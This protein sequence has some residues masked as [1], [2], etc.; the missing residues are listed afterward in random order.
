MRKLLTRRPIVCLNFTNCRIGDEQVRA[1]CS[2]PKLEQLWL[3]GC[4][5]SDAVLPSVAKIPKLKRLNLD[6]TRVN[7]S[8]LHAFA[9]NTV[10]ESL[11]LRGTDI[12]DAALA[13][14]LQIK[15]LSHLG[16][17]ETHVTRQGVLT[18]AALPLLHLGGAEP[19]FAAMQDDFIVEQRRLAD[20]TDPAFV[21]DAVEVAAISAALQG[22]MQA[23][24][25][26]E[27]KLASQSS[28][29][30]GTEEWNEAE[31][32]AIFDQFCTVKEREFSRS[33]ALSYQ[34]TS[35]YSQYRV[36]NTEWLSA[37]KVNVYA[38]D[39]DYR[40]CRFMLVK[41]AGR[42]LV[43][44]KQSLFTGWQTSYL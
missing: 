21:P 7:G 16:L 17:E 26:W 37:T 34:T 6:H 14:I 13:H 30:K 29:G 2:L 31:C 44:H 1:L 36:L 8:G 27:A 9:G 40:Q 39:P 35:E 33:N 23:M 10:L 22:F 4:D 32:R 20:A 24:A 19:R 38:V 5:V 25:A 11:S 42:W 3:E 41:K 12:D 43:D 18:L 15:G 28:P